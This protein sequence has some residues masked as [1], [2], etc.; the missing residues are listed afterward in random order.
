MPRFVGEPS[1]YQS[2]LLAVVR[3]QMFAGLEVQ[4]G[5]PVI[6][7]I[8]PSRATIFGYVAGDIGQLEGKA[9]VACTVECFLVIG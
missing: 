8:A 4:L 9:E 3:A 1:A 7:D 5:E 2:K 6:G